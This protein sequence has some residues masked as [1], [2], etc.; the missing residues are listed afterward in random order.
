MD[1]KIEEIYNLYVSNKL[2]NPNNVS[3]E[4]FSAADDSQLDALYKLGVEKK[5]FSQVN[6]ETFKSAF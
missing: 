6:Q 1:N 4:Q 5:L 3:L 2:I